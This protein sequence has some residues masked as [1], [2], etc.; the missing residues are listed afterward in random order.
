MEGIGLLIIKFMLWVSL[1]DLPWNFAVDLL[2]CVVACVI[3]RLDCFDL[4]CIA[5]LYPLCLILF[6][7]GYI[8]LLLVWFTWICLR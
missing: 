2:S 4:L 7:V 1:F 6:W 5:V 8:D 3:L